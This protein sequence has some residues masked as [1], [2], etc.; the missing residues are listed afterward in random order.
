MIRRDDEAEMEL[1]SFSTGARLARRPQAI[2]SSNAPQSSMSFSSTILI[3][4]WARVGAVGGGN[5]GAV[6]DEGGP[7][8]DGR[9]SESERVSE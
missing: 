1:A 7:D 3:W 6:V 4:T 5:G 8:D 9:D 2:Y